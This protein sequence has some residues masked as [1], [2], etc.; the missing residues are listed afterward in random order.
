MAFLI[1][2]KLIAEAESDSIYNRFKAEFDKLLIG[3]LSLP[4]NLPGTSYYH[5][6]KVSITYFV[7]IDY[8]TNLCLKIL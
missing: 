5:G 8:G 3:S 7:Q 1:A 2:F 4:I 6:L